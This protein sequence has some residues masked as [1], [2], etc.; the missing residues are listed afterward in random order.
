MTVRT[1]CEVGATAGAAV[2]LNGLWLAWPPLAWV[3]GGAAMLA[4]AVLRYPKED[5]PRK[6]DAK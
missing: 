3:V 1:I 6:D 5:E 4:M 2:L